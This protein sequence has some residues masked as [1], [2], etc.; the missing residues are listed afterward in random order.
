MGGHQ[1]NGRQD[2]Q[3]RTDDGSSRRHFLRR[4]GVTGAVAAAMVGVSDLAGLGQALASSGRRNCGNGSQTCTY[5]PRR[6]NGGRPCAP[7][8]C[9]YHCVGC[10]LNRY[11]C[12]PTGSCKSFTACC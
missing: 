3:A 4:M 2:D 12:I 9:C 6:C 8:Y 1:R 11:T 7:G 5:T 10:G